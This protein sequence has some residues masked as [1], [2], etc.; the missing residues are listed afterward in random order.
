MTAPSAR[1]RL[2][3]EQGVARGWSASVIAG[4]VGVSLD[5]VH[6]VWDDLDAA[7]AAADPPRRP[8]AVDQ[9]PV[10]LPPRG[11][12]AVPPEWFVD[13]RASVLCMGS[14]E[15]ACLDM[16]VSVSAA[17][18]RWARHHPTD[19][20]RLRLIKEAARQTRLLRALAAARGVAA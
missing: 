8:V 4:R 11:A 17:E 13:F 10:V 18:K 2:A 7:V 5:V 6:A 14:I 1:E 15:L 20:V 3:I 19:P 16:G 12:N 9:D